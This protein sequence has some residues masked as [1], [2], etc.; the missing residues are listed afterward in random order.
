MFRAYA[1]LMQHRSN[2]Q[3]RPGGFTLGATHP[4]GT[5]HG[6]ACIGRNQPADTLERLLVRRFQ[7]LSP[8]PIRDFDIPFI[9]QGASQPPPQV[10]QR[11]FVGQTPAATWLRKEPATLKLL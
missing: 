8:N 2:G 11:T 5:N 7:Y 6:A 4:G 3:E 9:V 10:C 1:A